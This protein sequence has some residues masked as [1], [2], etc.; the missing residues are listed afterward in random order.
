MSEKT[1]NVLYVD[2]EPQGLVSFYTSFR[3][4]FNVFTA[5]SAMEAETMLEKH[6]IHVLITDYKMPVKTGTEL[7]TETVKKY[8]DQTRILLTGHADKV[9]LIDAINNGQIY[10]Y[11]EKPWDY[12]TLERCIKEGYDDFYKRKY[13]INRLS[14]LTKQNR[15]LKRIIRKKR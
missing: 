4:V 1:I 2:D 9:V 6:T 7:L 8:P 15:N 13:H 5:N 10:M 12:E 3:R 11:L 14:I